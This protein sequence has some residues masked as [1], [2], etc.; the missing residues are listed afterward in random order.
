MASV[1]EE[2]EDVF[3]ASYRALQPLDVAAAESMLKEVKEIF[4][5]LGVVFFLSLRQVSMVRPS[6]QHK[7]GRSTLESRLIQAGST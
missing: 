7:G 5:Q 1:I 6:G 3:D 2:F 4:D